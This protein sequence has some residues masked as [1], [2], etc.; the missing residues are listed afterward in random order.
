MFYMKL[1]LSM[2]DTLKCLNTLP[3]DEYQIY[4]IDLIISLFI[5]LLNKYKANSHLLISAPYFTSE[6]CM[7][8][9]H[10]IFNPATFFC[11]SLAKI[12]HSNATWHCLL[13]GSENGRVVTIAKTPNTTVETFQLLLNYTKGT[14]TSPFNSLNTKKTM[15]YDVRNPGPGLWQEQTC[16]EADLVNG[17]ITPTSW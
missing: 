3:W 6:L 12:W 14:I 4:F 16:D 10:C 9:L 2:M 8:I 11:L 5:S 15:T 13:Q 7:Q 17:I 1:R